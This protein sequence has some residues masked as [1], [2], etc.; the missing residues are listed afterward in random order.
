M[1]PIRGALVARLSALHRRDLVL[2][3]FTLVD[4]GG[5]FLEVLLETVP[6]LVS[7]TSRTSVTPSTVGW[8][9]GW[10]M[11]GTLV[12]GVVPSVFPDTVER[13]NDRPSFKAVTAATAIG[14]AVVIESQVFVSWWSGAPFDGI[15]NKWFLF[16]G[17]AGAITFTA[18][19]WRQHNGDPMSPDGPFAALVNGLTPFF[20]VR[21]EQSSTPSRLVVDL[22]GVGVYLLICVFMGLV[23]FLLILLY[24][25][26]EVAVLLHVGLRVAHED[27][28]GLP[29]ESWAAQ[30]DRR[31]TAS[32]GAFNAGPKGIG[33]MVFI[34]GGVLISGFFAFMVSYG[35]MS[36]IGYTLNAIY[37]LN[38][39]PNHILAVLYMA[40]VIL[41]LGLL[42][43]YGI[44]FWLRVIERLPYFLDTWVHTQPKDMRTTRT[45]NETGS[46][47][48][49]P[50]GVMVP[51][52]VLFI[53][54][55]LMMPGC[56]ITETG[57]FPSLGVILVWVS[58][59]AG[60]CWLSWDSF[61][62]EP[63]DPLWDNFAIPVAFS[64][65]LFAIG[66]GYD[67]I[68]AWNFNIPMAHKTLLLF[69]ILAVCFYYPDAYTRLEVDG[70][71]QYLSEG[72]AAFLSANIAIQGVLA[73]DRLLVYYGIFSLGMVSVLT[74]IH[75]HFL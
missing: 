25:L 74:V 24:P 34:L 7:L 66:I 70:P 58:T 61:S 10:A 11:F 50:S 46:L 54:F 72:L 64:V 21:G 26:P 1:R 29:V 52:A 2:A 63:Q 30:I 56:D 32:V 55:S 23:V 37:D 59:V 39:S 6:A 28:V 60:V 33:S 71:G 16:V 57:C 51:W 75:Y 40:A 49:R 48:A 13:T 18:L 12:Y 27:D 36:Q 45:W 68:G 8:F 44:W 41:T 20:D 4:V 17:I 5:R 38:L 73:G 19:Q 3:V 53:T 62:A 9:A 31:L 65:Q 69:V 67:I 22:A 15:G 47:I 14:F 42:A 35:I 43:I